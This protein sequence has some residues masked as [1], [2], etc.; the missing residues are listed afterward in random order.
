MNLPKTFKFQSGNNI[1]N[2]NLVNGKYEITDNQGEG[3]AKWGLN[4]VKHQLEK[5]YWKIIESDNVNNPDHYQGKTE[6]IDIIE[7][8]TTDLNG[9]HA[10]CLGNVI[11][12][13]MRHQKKGGITDLKKAAWYLNK[14]IGGENE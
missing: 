6:V 1:F 11:K 14:V 9:F 2:A 5:G 10:Y 12:Y 8:A 7:Q 3:G 4:Q 13:V